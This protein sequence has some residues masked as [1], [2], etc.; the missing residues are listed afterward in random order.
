MLIDIPGI[1]T[2]KLSA[3][4]ELKL[5]QPNQ[6]LV[7]GEVLKAVVISAIGEGKLM[8]NLD[9]ANINAKTAHQFVPGEELKVKVDKQDGQIIL[10]VQGQKFSE[11]ILNQA[12]R[13]VLPKQVPATKLL[14]ISNVISQLPN[15]M[16]SK[17]PIEVTAQLKQITSQLPSLNQITNSS[18]LKSVI[19]N[20][21]VFLENKL[22]SIAG[23]DKPILNTQNISQDFKGQLLKLLNVLKVQISQ[24]S[25]Q[26]T[27]QEQ[28]TTISK[29]IASLLGKSPQETTTL[30]SKQTELLEN[31][32]RLKRAANFIR[33]TNFV[34]PLIKLLPTI[35]PSTLAANIINQHN[36]KAQAKQTPP[37]TNN[38]LNNNQNSKNLIKHASLPIKGAIPQPISNN[39]T[40]IDLNQPPHQLLQILK[41]EVKNVL[42]RIQA[43]QLS[44]LVK[45]PATMPTFLIDIPV[46][47]N[48]TKVDV[49]PVLIEQE[50]SS[51]SD[52]ENKKNW[53]ITIAL[54]LENLGPMQ[55]KVNLQNDKVN[56]NIWS[57][58][59][60]TKDL[61]E[62]KNYILEDS[63]KQDNIEVENLSYHKGLKENNID[64]ATIN[65]LDLKI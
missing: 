7:V 5:L 51:T 33:S 25:M 22:A 50:E 28:Q 9:G 23:S 26:P 60:E 63:L 35:S 15:N 11:S 1:Q 45:D 18:G 59:S 36:N 43:N 4:Q 44:T 37:S 49:M 20:S 58:L 14:N 57:K 48:E 40:K 2:Y 24:V 17:L 30:T 64:K 12:I 39:Q 27:A 13:E 55:L 56:I 34:Q 65:L 8:L 6:G 29:D 61:L 21:G 19:Q 38:V 41:D 16:Q 3:G 32:S 62:Q 53:A 42:S 47:V 54:D 31:A 52:N 46:K 10:K